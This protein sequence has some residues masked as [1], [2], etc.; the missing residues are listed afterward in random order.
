MSTWEMVK[1]LDRKEIAAE[2]ERKYRNQMRKLPPEL[3]RFVR[4]L[5]HVLKVEPGPENLHREKIMKRL[6]IGHSRYYEL[7]LMAERFLV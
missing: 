7:R 6:Q 3:R 5:R 1:W 2:R 4:V